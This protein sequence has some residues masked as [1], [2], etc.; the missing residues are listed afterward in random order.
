MGKKYTIPTKP[1]SDGDFW[2]ENALNA[3]IDRVYVTSCKNLSQL[4]TCWGVATGRTMLFGDGQF[5]Q[6][7]WITQQTGK[8][9]HEEYT[10]IY[11]DVGFSAR[12][13]RFVR[14]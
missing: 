10:W 14:S 8:A 13:A 4:G 6:K 5:A 1:D 2:I 9:I 7:G 11:K 12:L 3:N